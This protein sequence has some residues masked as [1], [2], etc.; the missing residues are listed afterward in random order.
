M[1]VHR[2]KFY[3]GHPQL[4]QVIGGFVRAEAG[5]G[6]AQRFRNG[7]HEAGEAFDV[8]FIDAGAVQG[9]ARSLV[10]APVEAGVHDHAERGERGRIM[11]VE[12]EI[13]MFVAKR[14]AKQF[15]APLLQGTADGLGVGIEQNLVGIEAVTVFRL[16]GAMHPV[17]VKLAA[18]DAM[19]KTMP[20]LIGAFRQRDA[21]FG[22]LP[23]RVEEAK[24]DLGCIG[25]KKGEIDPA[26]PEGGTEGGG[27][28]GQDFDRAAHVRWWK[29]QTK[30]Y[31]AKSHE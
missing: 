27:A 11:L 28:S 31:P 3:R 25:G 2:Q 19:H 18:P 29:G 26:L 22:V 16:I 23:G 15:R 20:H 9:R 14:V 24:L 1:V 4:L 17:A 8:K 6:A 7:L 13:R 5:I 30:E 12:T 21:R 10:A